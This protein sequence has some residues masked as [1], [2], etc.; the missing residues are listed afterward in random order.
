MHLNALLPTSSPRKRKVREMLPMPPYKSNDLMA[1]IARRAV[2][3]GI[4]NKMLL[5]PKLAARF[6]HL[7]RSAEDA[8]T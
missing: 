3:P 2:P 1:K 4:P 6:A 7:A 5:G 8:P